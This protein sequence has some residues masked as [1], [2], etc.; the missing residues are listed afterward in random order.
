M[1]FSLHSTRVSEIRPPMDLM[2]S[3]QPRSRRSRRPRPPV[4]RPYNHCSKCGN[5]W[6]YGTKF[7]CTCSSRGQLPVSTHWSVRFISSIPSFDAR[8]KGLKR[9]ESP[10]LKFDEPMIPT[11]FADP[12]E[13]QRIQH[14]KGYSRGSSETVSSRKSS[15]QTS[16]Y[17][18]IWTTATPPMFCDQPLPLVNSPPYNYSSPQ[19]PFATSNR[20]ASV[21]APTP[22]APRAQANRQPTPVAGAPNAVYKTQPAIPPP[23]QLYSSNGSLI[24][25][26]TLYADP[27]SSSVHR[28]N[29]RHGRESRNGTRPYRTSSNGQYYAYY[30]SV[31]CPIASPRPKV[32]ASSSRRAMIPIHE[33]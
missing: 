22:V 13:N 16:L 26:N 14:I 30:P 20:L 3:P 21:L 15:V 8:L 2:H 24:P 25:P 29:S 1:L 27:A 31:P 5:I 7:S 11:V 19:V 9:S 18:P 23:P 17:D 10:P 32:A 12:P 33:M 4:D 6:D 28:R